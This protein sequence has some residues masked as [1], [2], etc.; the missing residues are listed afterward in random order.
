MPVCA[1]A[2]AATHAGSTTNPEREKRV[3]GGDIGAWQAAGIPVHEEVGVLRGVE[4]HDPV[5]VADVQ[6]PSCAN[7]SCASVIES[8]VKNG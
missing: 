4:L 8:D 1:P 3:D 2:T 6:T 7:V 5:H